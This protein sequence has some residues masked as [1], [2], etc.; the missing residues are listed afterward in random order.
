MRERHNKRAARLPITYGTTSRTITAA[1]KNKPSCAFGEGNVGPPRAI[2]N[3]RSATTAI[4]I[5]RPIHAKPTSDRPRR[6]SPRTISAPQPVQTLADA[7][8]CVWQCGHTSVFTS[9]TIHGPEYGTSE[10]LSGLL[11]FLDSN[12]NHDSV[13]AVG[14]PVVALW[15]CANPFHC[16]ILQRQEERAEVAS[17]DFD[18]VR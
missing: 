12:A 11:R 10:F 18:I 16:E 1:T 3:A 9:A 17:D 13:L 14:Q 15:N 5:A 7:G 2:S 8:T 4:R 6:E